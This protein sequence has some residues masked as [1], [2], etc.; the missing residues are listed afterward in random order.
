MKPTDRIVTAH[1][2]EE[3]APRR[4]TL[5]CVDVLSHDGP[6][7]QDCACGELLYC[8]RIQVPREDTPHLHARA[9]TPIPSRGFKRSQQHNAKIIMRSTLSCAVRLSRPHNLR[10]VCMPAV[11]VLAHS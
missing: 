11:R 3:H 7:P 1:A 10:Y 5:S 6:H 4:A 8:A 2:S 9:V